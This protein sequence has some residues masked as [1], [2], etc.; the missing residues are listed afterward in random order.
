MLTLEPPNLALLDEYAAALR[1]GWSPSTVRDVTAEQLAAI[2]ANPA[3]FIDAYAWRPGA[4]TTDAQGRVVERLPGFTR[5]MWDGAFC[6]AINLRHLLGTEDLPP[7]VSGHVGYSVVPWKRRRGHATAAL[8]LMLPLA[9][10]A[11]LSRVKLTCDADNI[12]S[13]R[14]IQACGGVSLGD[15]VVIDE[16]PRGRLQFWVPTAN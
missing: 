5:W 2:E 14:V 10:A 8:R 7:H 6:G 12:A 16:F 9:A 13:A 4:T 1:A 15:P 3:G 11:G